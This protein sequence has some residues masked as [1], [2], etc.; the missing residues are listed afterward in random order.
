MDLK[1]IINELE[2]KDI[3]SVVAEE[4]TALYLYGSSVKGRLREESDVDIAILPSH[5]IDEEERLILIAKVEGVID[6]LLRE[7]GTRREISILD[8]RGKFVPLT[9]QYKV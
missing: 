4:L 9:L 7:K 1:M 2:L 3:S 5:K 8:L 6:K